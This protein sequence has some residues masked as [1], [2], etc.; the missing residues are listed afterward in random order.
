VLDLTRSQ[1][2]LAVAAMLAILLLGARYLHHTAAA[3]ATPHRAVAGI[4][5][6]RTAGYGAIVHVAG[7][8]RR[9]GVYRFAA[10]ARVQ[11]AVHRAGGATRHADLS[12]LN[13]AAKVTDGVQILVP[14]KG[15]AVSGGAVAGG[16]QGA[17]PQAA[18][19][20]P[21]AA[22]AAPAQPVNLNTATLEQLETLDGVGPAT[23]QKILAYRQQHGGFRSIDELDQVSGIGPK[24]MAALREQV[25]V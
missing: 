18:G 16:T 13:L 6:D 5:V 22:S 24:K 19:S 4:R 10:G 25:R 21:G 23:A 20:P 9:P 3:P 11:D 14:R 17:A 7:A 2:A 15:P 8:V 12:A 1:L